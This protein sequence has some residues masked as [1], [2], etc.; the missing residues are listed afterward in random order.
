MDECAARPST[1]E[2]PW[3]ENGR[4][5]KREKFFHRFQGFSTCS[6]VTSKES[7]TAV[8]P[9]SSRWLF[10][11]YIFGEQIFFNMF[12]TRGMS[13]VKSWFAPSLDVAPSSTISD[14]IGSPSREYGR[15]GNSRT[16]YWRVPRPRLEQY[17]R[18]WQGPSTA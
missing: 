16:R 3:P 10:Y 18:V 13:S 7:Q 2:H 11:N 12:F 14:R 5:G 1:R 8:G 17:L 15:I 4:S 6:A 9:P